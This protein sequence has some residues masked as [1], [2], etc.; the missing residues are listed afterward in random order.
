MKRS[1]RSSLFALCSLFFALCLLPLRTASASTPLI[2]HPRSLIPALRSATPVA[3]SAASTSIAGVF[4]A[5]A[6]PYSC[7]P[8]NSSFDNKAC[9]QSAIND[10]VAYAMTAPHASAVAVELDP[11]KYYLSGALVQN[12]I[13]NAQ[14]TIPVVGTDEHGPRPMLTIRSKSPSAGPLPY[15]TSISGANVIF[16]STLTGLSYSG[17]YG[18]P[19][20]LAGPDPIHGTGFNSHA[21]L[22]LHLK[23]VGFEAPSNPSLCGVNAQMIDSILV[24]DAVFATTDLNIGYP[25][26]V[27]PTH[28]T[29][30]SVLTPINGFNGSEYRG[31]HVTGWYG[32]PG[33][34]E[35]TI[36]SGGLY[37]IQNYVGLNLQTPY[38]QLAEL[39]GNLVRNT[40]QVAQ[41]DPSSGVVAPAGI[42]NTGRTHIYGTLAIEDYVTSESGSARWFSRVADIYD[43]NNTL[44]GELKYLRIVA[45]VG[46]KTGG[47]ALNG[48]AN[49]S[50]IDLSQRVTSSGTPVYLP[51]GTR[52]SNAHIVSSYARLDENGAATI[53]LSGSAAFSAT[54]SYR[55]TS[56]AIKTLSAAKFMTVSNISSS[57]FEI[58]GGDANGYASFICVGN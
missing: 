51:D 55:C 33:I 27:Q 17:A 32:G 5:N 28:P 12:S 40:Y 36:I 52:Q 3:F 43:P 4:N 44:G 45:N 19:C 24:E 47:L 7:V 49:L 41:V 21:F 14:L 16:K 39:K 48:A 26:A 34:G 53:T 15:G 18:L 20:I 25:T 56:N 35:L 57:S 54:G 31:I 38:Y 46:N 8:N 29:G 13:Y 11:G 10:A 23:G 37:S 6:A 1:L 22:G 58:R 42:G 30:V 2:P 50:L 9:L